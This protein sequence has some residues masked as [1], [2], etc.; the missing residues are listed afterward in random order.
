MGAIWVKDDMAVSVLM[1]QRVAA[2]NRTMRMK[3]RDGRIHR[4][5]LSRTKNPFGTEMYRII[6]MNMKKYQWLSRVIE[7]RGYALEQGRFCAGGEPVDW[8]GLAV[9]HNGQQTILIDLH[10]RHIERGM[11][12]LDGLRI[13]GGVVDRVAAFFLN[14]FL[15]M[16]H[17]LGHC[18]LH[19][20]SDQQRYATEREYYEKIEF[21]AWDFA[22]RFMNEWMKHITEQEALDLCERIKQDIINQRL[23]EYTTRK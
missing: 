15:T 7:L 6:R 22:K 13:E 19:R 9:E 16:L 10:E 11:R 8:G 21:E 12:F 1:S 20:D 5:N 4:V 2:S 14:L 18:E 23:T 3:L 17:E